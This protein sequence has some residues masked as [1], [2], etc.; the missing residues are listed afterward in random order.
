MDVFGAN[1]LTQFN[2]SF[3]GHVGPAADWGAGGRGCDCW[4]EGV[5]VSQGHSWRQVAVHLIW[6]LR[7]GNLT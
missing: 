2:Y 6:F 4:G 3:L 7:L 5:S 1:Y